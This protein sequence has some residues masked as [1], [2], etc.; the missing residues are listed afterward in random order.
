MCIYCIA[1]NYNL[2]KKRIKDSR[3]TFRE[4]ASFTEMT[5]AGLRKAIEGERL[6]VNAFEKICILLGDNPSTYLDSGYNITGNQNQ[7]GGNG[8]HIIISPEA[9]EI[10]ALK[11]RIKDLEKIIAT[12][13]KTIELLTKNK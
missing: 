3:V 6:S 12:Q 8:N 11:Q 9:A 13:E 7:I 2:L 4:C 5:E 10:D 1:M